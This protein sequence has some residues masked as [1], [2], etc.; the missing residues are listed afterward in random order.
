M[1]LLLD[2]QIIIWLEENPAN[3]ANEVRDQILA[4]TT[5]YFSKASVWEMAIKIKTGKLSLK[6]PLDLFIDNFQID[7]KFKLLDIS[8]QHIYQTQQLPL[9]HRDPFDRL[10]I[11]QSIIENIAVISSDGIFDAYGIRRIW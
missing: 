8:L 5:A 7:Y 3:I 2:T 10:L 9:H 6:Q 11:A 4:E 1:A